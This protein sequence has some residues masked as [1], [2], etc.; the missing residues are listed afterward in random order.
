M[1]YIPVTGKL[2][3]NFMDEFQTVLSNI[4]EKKPQGTEKHTDR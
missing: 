3:S 2:T 1:H 4:R